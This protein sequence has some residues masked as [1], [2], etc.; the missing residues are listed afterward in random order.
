MTSV[1]LSST[2]QIRFVVTNA[3]GY[4]TL[5]DD[6][7]IV[8]IPSEDVEMVS[9]D[10][11]NTINSGGIN[12]NG[13]FRN[14]G[15]S[16][17][18]SLD[19]N[20]QLNGGLIYTQSLSSLNLSTG[21][22]FNFSHDEV[23][24]ASIG[25]YSLNVW[26]S[27]VNGNGL[28]DVS[29][30]DLLS[31]TIN[32]TDVYT[33]RPLFETYS[34]STCGPCATF[35]N[36]AFNT[37]FKNLNDSKM[38]YIKFPVNWPGAGDPYAEQFCSDR[39]SYY[40]VNGAPTTYLDGSQY[41]GGWSSTALESAL[42]SRI[43]SGESNYKIDA[44][45]SINGQIINI[46]VDVTSKV[47]QQAIL[48]VVVFE[49]TTSQNIGTN[50]QTQFY[51]ITMKMVPGSAGAI[52]NFTAGLTDN[53]TFTADMSSTNIESDF[54]NDAGIVVFLQE[55]GSGREIYQS[56]YSNEVALG[57]QDGIQLAKTSI[58]P[59]PSS[60]LFKIRT[61]QE[62][63]NVEICDLNGRAVLSQNNLKSGDSVSI[64]NLNY[65]LYVVKLSTDSQ[66]KFIKLVKN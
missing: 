47:T 25:T 41:N 4:A 46:N 50:G 13:V 56:N 23:W 64:D 48:H 30:N 11:P 55:P 35:D 32:V 45:H 12:I 21:N 39:V 60:D 54:I 38:T 22:S 33:R 36:N 29:S 58:F 52:H 1:T 66:E 3:Y 44:I 59:N 20:Y 37:S 43:N 2:T 62:F 10:V 31:K 42:N 28:D 34:S 57:I 49:G 27:N 53:F 61:N 15:N 65:G 26:V 14:S 19:L 18:N 17:I 16:T 24:N 7:S 5:L 51:H 63:I 6:I 8:E 40:G 9:I